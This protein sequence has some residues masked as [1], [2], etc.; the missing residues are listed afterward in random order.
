MS[1]WIARTNTTAR[2]RVVVVTLLILNARKPVRS[3]Q[4][5]AV[6]VMATDKQIYHVNGRTEFIYSN[7]VG[8]IKTIFFYK[9]FKP[10]TSHLAAKSKSDYSGVTGQHV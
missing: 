8:R 9:N 4:S 6:R 10:I 5:L 3:Y 2:H 7:T 1:A